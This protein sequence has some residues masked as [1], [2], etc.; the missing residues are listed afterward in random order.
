MQS[1]T[2]VQV[3][4]AHLPSLQLPEQRT[5]GSQAAS[6]QA[7]L[8]RPPPTDPP[9]TLVLGTPARWPSSRAGSGR[10]SGG[11]AGTRVLLG[12]LWVQLH[13]VRRPAMGVV[14]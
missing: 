3:A 1:E 9:P 8:V 13:L 6:A 2:S 10:V 5:E 7:R 14:P 11:G 4:G 12:S